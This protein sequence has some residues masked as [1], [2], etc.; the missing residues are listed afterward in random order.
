MW[1]L[2]GAGLA[3]A[4]FGLVLLAEDARLSGALIRADLFDVLRLGLYWAWVWMVW[5]SAPNV[6]RAVWTPVGRILALLGVGLMFLI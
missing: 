1:W 5:K 4:V 2:Y 3:C 6:R